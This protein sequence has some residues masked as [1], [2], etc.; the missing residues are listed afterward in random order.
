MSAELQGAGLQRAGPE[1]DALDARV[2]SLAA[3]VSDLE[4]QLRATAVTADAKALKELAKALEAWSKHDPKLEARITNR[5]DVLADRFATLSGTV[6]T[7]AAALAGK[8]GEIA[9]LRRELEAGTARIEALVHDLRRSGPNADVAELRKAVA[10]LS[11][12]RN[13]APA[14]RRIDSIASE[15]DVVA[16]RLDTLSKTVSTTA[17]ALAGKEGELISLRARLEEGDTRAESL[18]AELRTTVVELSHQVASS[19]DRPHDLQTSRAFENHL[20]DLGSRVKQLTAGLDAVSTTVAATTAEVEANE[21]EL[22]DVQRRFEEASARVEAMVAELHEI[23]STLPAQGS[24]DRELEAALENRIAEVSAQVDGLAAGLSRL[25]AETSLRAEAAA[26]ATLELERLLDAG[27]HRLAQVE[28]VSADAAS[29]LERFGGVWIEERGWVRE[30]LDLLA[31]AVDKARP[32]GTVEPR[33]QSLASRIEAMEHGQHAVDHEVSQIASAWADERDALRRELESV[34]ASVANATTGERTVPDELTEELLSA[35]AAKLEEME[36]EGIAV[37]A[38]ISRV[39]STWASEL[40]SLEARLQEIAGAAA[41]SPHGPDSD[42]DERFGELV[43][44]LELLELGAGSSSGEAASDPGELRDIRVLVNGLRMRLASSEK[45]LAA[46]SGSG[47]IV[48]RL[49]DLSVRLGLLER[50]AASAPQHAPAPGDG[51]FRVELRGL[52]LR[53]QEL[54]LSAR[55]NRDAVLTQ[56]E[57]LASRLQWRLQQ[58]ELETS[59]A[60][61]APSAS[62]PQLGQVVPIRGEA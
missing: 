39:E 58:L 7:T 47:D 5:V 36:R 17:A 61:Y 48:P 52:E 3:W 15:V 55:E 18:V 13:A 45:E 14:E 11:S 12:D 41:A 29:E 38:E 31:A 24:V 20:L 4:A 16:Q 40:G 19:A 62:T 51:R 2:D 28:R 32:D 44:R 1:S 43:R 27:T 33:L 42:T 10:S 21:A 22:V 25:E 37:A 6:N 49:D 56:F 34:A 46:L 30:Q 23:D 8:D 54:E 53:M 50:T 9:Q 59:D 35:L 57:R 60:G 26:T